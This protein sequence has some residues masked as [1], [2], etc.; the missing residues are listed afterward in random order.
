VYSIVIS[1]SSSIRLCDPVAPVGSVSCSGSGSVS[2]SGS[3]SVSCS[4]SG[5]VSC[6]G[7][8]SV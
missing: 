4:G 5:S 7:S 1:D 6:S 3:G 8:G 2:C